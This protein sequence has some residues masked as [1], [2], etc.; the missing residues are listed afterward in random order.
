[1]KSLSFVSMLILCLLTAPAWAQVTPCNP[2]KSVPNTVPC[3]DLDSGGVKPNPCVGHPCPQ[4]QLGETKQ[5]TVG[6]VTTII[7]PETFLPEPERS[8]MIVPPGTNLLPNV[9]TDAYDSLGERMCNTLPSTPAIPYNLHDGEPIVTEINPTSPSEDLTKIF[10]ETLRLSAT[11]P[12]SPGDA[13]EIIRNLTM[14]IDILEGNEVENRVYSGFPLL[15]YNGPEKVKTVE[16][17]KNEKGET[18]GGN[19]H[20]RQ[21]WYDTHFESD[22]ALL[23]VSQVWNVPWT[24]TYTIDVLSRGYD[25]FS[26]FNMYFDNPDVKGSSGEGRVTN[27]ALDA[28]FFPMN[29]GTRTVLDIK[30]AQGK[31]YNLIYTWGW[32]I[33]PPRIQAV[34]NACKNVAGKTTVQWEVDTFG[35]NPTASRENQLA[36]IAKIGDLAPAKRMWNHLNKALD[37]ANKGNWDKVKKQ[38]RKAQAAYSDW[39]NRAHLPDGV[40]I[41]PESDITLF[42]ANNTIYAQFTDGGIRDFPKWLKRGTE[43]KVTL[44]N[45]DYFEHGYLNVDFGGARGWENQFKSSVRVGGSGCWF[46]FGR[47]YYHINMNKPVILDPAKP[48]SN[49]L[50]THKVHITYN[51]EPG[52]RLRFYQFDPLHHDVAIFSVH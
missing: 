27:V 50:P 19:V 33:H 5:T 18:I 13:G 30:M 46:T 37:A 41:D 12:G 4:P 44:K 2:P 28:T 34:D 8:P 10:G 51:W 42:Y 7:T 47:A 36:A 21:I 52:R 22:T 24:I 25:D 11:A 48:N 49:T 39:F 31:Y 26:P 40:E 23:D 14:G 45:G 9:F 1:M 17:I 6:N 3:N 16:P 20:I 32:R 38:T 15:H 35:P 43:L 29:E